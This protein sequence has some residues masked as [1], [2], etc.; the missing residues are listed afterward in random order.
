MTKGISKA[1][2]RPS[3]ARIAA[4]WSMGSQT[5]RQALVEPVIASV[6]IADERMGFVQSRGDRWR[7]PLEAA[8]THMRQRDA[9]DKAPVNRR[10]ENDPFPPPPHRSDRGAPRNFSSLFSQLCKLPHRKD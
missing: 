2:G 5:A 7:V 8:S 6:Q 4:G 1:S 10:V 9:C 3:K